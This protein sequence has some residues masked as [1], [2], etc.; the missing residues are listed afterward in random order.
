MKWFKWLSKR[1]NDDLEFEQKYGDLYKEKKE[2]ES[3][4][5]EVDEVS[6]TG[7][8]QVVQYTIN[9]CEIMQESAKRIEDTKIEFQAVSDYLSDVQMIESL[10]DNCF[11]KILHL[12]KKVLVLEKDRKE[13][14]GSMSKMSNRQFDLM[15]EYEDKIKD[16]LK[17]LKEDEE[18]CHAVYTDLHYLNGEKVALKQ[19]KREMKDRI[20]M[21]S[22][23][24]KISVGA[25]IALLAIIF[26]VQINTD[27]FVTGY[28]YALMGIAAVLATTLFVVHHE[29]V[30]N[31]SL[32]ER[33]QAKA[34]NLINKYKLRYV[35]VKSRIDYMYEKF[36]VQNSY[37]LNKIWG[38]YLKVKKEQE[39]YHKASDKLYEAEEELVNELSNYNLNDSEIWVN[40]AYAIVDSNELKRIRDELIRRRNALTNNIEY[41]S[42]VIDRSKN[43]IKKLLLKYPDYAK[44]I[45][46][47]VESY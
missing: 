27:V 44:E 18:Y 9:Q 22:G 13:F 14:G 2:S 15:K 16:V 8:E 20:R 1:K 28:L 26:L 29:A 31:I 21:V 45:Q 39:V 11:Q 43:N 35:N 36:G 7:K 34:I 6:F 32:I 4:I 40:Q 47:V 25:F 19:E 37:E 23:I 3:E 42:D 46:E 30:S 38:Q 5:G 17:D 10:P 33:K 41:N 24:S 12:A